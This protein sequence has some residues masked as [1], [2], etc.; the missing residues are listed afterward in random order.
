MMDIAEHVTFVG[1]V[2]RPLGEA[3]M[4][5]DV[6]RIVALLGEARDDDADARRVAMQGCVAL[7]QLVLDFKANH[8]E[9]VARKVAIGE[10]G[11]IAAVIGGHGAVQGARQGARVRVAGTRGSW[12]R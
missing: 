3:M 4:A 5:A 6:G 8:P 7:G 12:S 1:E 9:K 2:G 11:G 10:A